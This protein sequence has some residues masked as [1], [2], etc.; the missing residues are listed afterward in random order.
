M[1]PL[2]I[3]AAVGLE[4]AATVYEP[5]AAGQD[6]IVLI[7]P[8]TAVK[9]GYYDGYA[10]FLAE[11]GLRVVTFDYR[12]I[13]DSRPASLRGCRA[14]M[15]DWAEQDLAGVV[16]WIRR[17]YTGARLVVVGHSAGGQFVGLAQNNDRICAMLAVAA[18]SGYWGYW[19]SPRK[20]LMAALW[21]VLMPALTRLASY[22]PGKR[23]G[24]GEDLPRGV[25]LEWA[26]WCRHPQFIVDAEGRP[27]RENFRKFRAPIR[28][29]SFAD[30]P[31]A[32]R[33]A[34]EALLDFYANAPHTLTHVRPSDVGAG[35][36]GHFG[37]FRDRFRA[38]LWR[39]SAQWLLAQ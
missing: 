30:D 33:R 36:I 4:L 16:E 1:P 12:G 9:R 20:Y 18:Q 3:T 34:V 5:T 39:D 8:A 31:Y 10:R 25:A 35:A 11:Q 27:L 7:A 2:S 6:K 23:I 13:G 15:R 32:P 19:D 26:R 22:F 37:F 17:R 21:Y 28:A 29:Y 38:S 24:L 14:S